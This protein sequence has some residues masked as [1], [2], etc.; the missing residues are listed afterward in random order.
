MSAGAR[1][2][3][4]P[5]SPSRQRRSVA[6]QPRKVPRPPRERRRQTT[7]TARAAILAVALA[8]VALAVALPFKI[9]WTQRGQ[10]A[11]L[12]A[13]TRTTQAAVDRLTAQQKRWQD[14]AYVEQQ[15]QQRLHYVLPGQKTYIV[16][17][18]SN[19]AHSARRSTEGQHLSTSPW[20][21]Q[22]WQ[23]VQAAGR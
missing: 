12:S 22:L 1:A 4:K 5:K 3:S 21:S 18:K 15:A 7:L 23:S 17:G 11:S 16:Y 2:G 20:Y 10:I 13:Q 14:P 9:W 6:S 8:A 19:G